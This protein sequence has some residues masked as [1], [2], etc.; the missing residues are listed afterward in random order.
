MSPPSCV[1]CE[2][3]GGVASPIETSPEALGWQVAPQPAVKAVPLSRGAADGAPAHP[4]SGG[5]RAQPQG[6]WCLDSRRAVG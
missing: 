5:G 4:L 3:G 1:L 2:G 6:S